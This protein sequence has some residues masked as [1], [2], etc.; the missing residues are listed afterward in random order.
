M[1]APA[2]LSD[3]TAG[4]ILGRRQMSHNPLPL[5]RRATLF[6]SASGAAAAL[7]NAS[8]ATMQTIIFD[9]HCRM[10]D[11]PEGSVRKILL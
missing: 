1:I 3:N 8:Q 4:K 6:L 2:F 10:A 11:D 7:A 9:N 5:S